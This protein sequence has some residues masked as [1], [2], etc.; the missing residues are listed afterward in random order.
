MPRLRQQDLGMRMS[1]EDGL[2]TS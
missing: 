2:K 1:D